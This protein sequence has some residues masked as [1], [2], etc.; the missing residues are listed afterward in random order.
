MSAGLG[1]NKRARRKPARRSSAPS[2]AV[3]PV[4]VAPVTEPGFVP[5]QLLEIDQRLDEVAVQERARL[6][7]RSQSVIEELRAHPRDVLGGSVDREHGSARVR[8]A[9]RDVVLVTEDIE[10]LR[11]VVESA[12]VLPTALHTARSSGTGP[13]VLVFSVQDWTV[14][15]AA[16][17]VLSVDR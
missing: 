4:T 1:W 13:S 15:I 14:V 5:E 7:V 6:A 16:D 9:D 11:T 12:Q 10:E 2:A 8:F 3:A 17:P